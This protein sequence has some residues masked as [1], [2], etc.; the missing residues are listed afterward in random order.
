[1]STSRHVLLLLGLLALAV[2]S[3]QAQ[4][5]KAQAL[6][7]ARAA[8]PSAGADLYGSWWEGTLSTLQFYDPA[9][10]HWEAP[11]GTGT[12]LI[13]RADGTFRAGGILNV[14][15]G[16]CTSTLM[17]D[18][19]GTYAASA[20]SLVLRREAGNSR[21]TN[22]CSS[23][24]YTRVLDPET[25]RFGV[26]LGRDGQG[27]DTLT[28]TQ[29]GAFYG[30]M[31]RWSTSSPGDP[32]GGTLTVR[33]FD[34]A[35]PQRTFLAESMAPLDTGFVFGTNVWQDKEK[36]ALLRLPAGVTSALVR[37]VGL[38]FGYRKP[39]APGLYIVRIYEGDAES[40]PTTYLGSRV[41]AIDQIS[42]DADLETPSAPTRLDFAAPVNG[43]PEPVRVG[44]TF[45][46]SVWVGDATPSWI[47]D[48]IALASSEYRSGRVAGV[49]EKWSDN[50]W[51]NVS[52]VWTGDGQPGSGTGGWD[53]WI[54]ATV[55]PA[56]ATPV[57]P[58]AEV[59]DAVTLA[60][61]YPNPFNPTTTLRFDLPQAA[62]VTLRVYDLTGR[63][64]ATL[65][66]GMR[67]SGPHAVT[68][69]AQQLPSGIY[70][71]R[72]QADSGV[73]TQKLT[74]LK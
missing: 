60:P 42:A 2:S 63:A 1:M 45:W 32:G 52:D 53:L 54:E 34:A 18:E 64:V 56:T 14:T 65:V 57:D 12:F 25:K 48:R 38:Y 46:V 66:E 33:S 7:P 20:D 67:P 35:A 50:S 43:T 36:A 6:A 62:H 68:F 24:V 29:D 5:Q 71:A 61:A 3:A 40:G 19:R 16:Y 30:T 11:N 22:T 37:D 49:W 23:Q 39:G 4:P 26:A 55:T 17:V 58:S 21:T 73:A 44:P 27:H 74:L 69:D 15:T 13:I 59:P 8:L 70:L 72:L 10:G 9:T 41:G 51:H 47:V 31:R 28:R